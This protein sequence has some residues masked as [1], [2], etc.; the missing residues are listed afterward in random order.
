MINKTFILF[1]RL[2]NRSIINRE[3]DKSE[4]IEIKQVYNSMGFTKCYA[5]AEKHKLLPF[6]AKLLNEIGVDIVHWLPIIN[7]YRTRNLHV[8]HELTKIYE[9]FYLNGIHK[10][11]VT[12]N[13]GAMLSADTDIGLFASGDIDNYADIAEYDRICAAFSQRGYKKKDRFS[14]HLLISTNFTNNELLPKNFEIG[15]E[16]FPLSRLKL[17]CFVEANKFINWNLL[18]YYKDTRILL[19]S[20]DVLMY[21]CLLHITLHTYCRAPAIRLYRDIVNASLNM[22]REDWE[23]VERLAKED[24]VCRR[25]AA[26]AFIAS[27]LGEVNIPN[28]IVQCAHGKEKRLLKL[29]FIDSLKII[30]PEPSK[31]RVFLV[32]LLNNDFGVNQGIR[33]LFFPNRVWMQQVYGTDRIVSY[34]KHIKGIV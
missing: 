27:K 25:I 31:Y 8:L 15:I 30:R 18:S 12:E 23:N 2:C 10:V 9:I 24:K 20:P 26:S 19:P 29:V 6:I 33:E 13:F 4:I 16:W 7:S 28:E 21:I 1:S 3:L 5:L 14:G 17:P 22:T 32:E 11:F 34:L